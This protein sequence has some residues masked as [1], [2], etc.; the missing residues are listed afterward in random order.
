MT[1]HRPEIHRWPEDTPE[2]EAWCYQVRCE[3]GHRGARHYAR[4]SAAAERLEHL[5]EVSPPRS[6]RCRDPRRHRMRSWDRCPLCA[7]QPALPGMTCTN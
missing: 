6:E 3:C 7:D 2:G 4:R 5:A 1:R